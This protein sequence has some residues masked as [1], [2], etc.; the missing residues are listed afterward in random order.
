M[1]W[2]KDTF[3]MKNSNHKLMHH[4]DLRLKF[5]QIVSSPSTQVIRCQHGPKLLRFL[6]CPSEAN[7]KTPERKNIALVPA[8]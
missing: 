3:S 4:M 7:E 6:E 2:G 1:D 8:W 5:I